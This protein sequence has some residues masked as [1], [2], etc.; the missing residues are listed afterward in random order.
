MNT[1]IEKYLISIGFNKSNNHYY[2]NVNNIYTHS[3]EYFYKDENNKENILSYS[4]YSLS[5]NKDEFYL[6][7][8]V[9]YFHKSKSKTIKGIKS[10]LKKYKVDNKFDS[11]KRF[12]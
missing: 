5:Y 7:T 3:G 4:S 2:L 8:P 6:M 11:S 9:G 1:D 12:I 10:F